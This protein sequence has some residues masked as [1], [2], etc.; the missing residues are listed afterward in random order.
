VLTFDDQSRIAVERTADPGPLREAIMAA[1]STGRFTALHDALYDASRYLRDAPRARK[2]IVLLTDGRDENSALNL[3]DA[4]AVATGSGIPVFA[5]GMGRLE[6]RT[7][8]RIAKLTG[9]DYVPLDQASAVTLAGAIE[10]TPLAAVP[11]GSLARPTALVT[12]PATSPPRS[13]S[14]L[15]IALVGGVIVASVLLAFGLSRRPAAARPDLEPSKEADAAPPPAREPTAED[16]VDP[17]F[18]PTVIGRLDATEEYLEKTIALHETPTLVVQGGPRSGQF[19]ALTEASITC[20]GRAKANDVV[21][22]DVSVS[23]Q[24]CRIR[25]ED[26]RFVLHDLKSTNGSF[27]N[28]QRVSRHVLA[29]GDVVKLGETRLQFKLDRRRA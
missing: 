26:G 18:S 14:G 21:L 10:N 19:Y 5:V 23:A 17:A 29:A 8:R 12:T 1:R 20:I 24:H 27:V 2:A 28:E 16:A 15:W 11:P 9:G 7:L 22:D 25:Y 6:E 3:D 13:R 4:L